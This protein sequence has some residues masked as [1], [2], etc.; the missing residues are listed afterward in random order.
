MF[1]IRGYDQSLGPT[2]SQQC[3]V[4]GMVEVDWGHDGEQPAVMVTRHDIAVKFDHGTDGGAA[5]S[6]FGRLRRTTFGA[7]IG[8]EFRSVDAEQTNTL[9]GP[10]D[11]DDDRIPINVTCHHSDI[12]CPLCRPAP[13]KRYGQ[14]QIRCGSQSRSISVP[15][16]SPPPQHIEMRPNR[17]ELR[18]N[19]WSALVMRKAPVAPRG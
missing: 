9:C 18:S 1:P 8:E 6:E 7:S 3:G 12:R 5:R 13:Q 11:V 19:S 17:P 16:P 14:Y 2:M 4:E 10:T 15:V